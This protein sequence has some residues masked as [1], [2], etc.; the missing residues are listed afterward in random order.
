MRNFR[1]RT[2][3]PD[4]RL[5]EETIR[6]VGDLN[7]VIDIGLQIVDETKGRAPADADCEQW[8]V[9]IFDAREHWIMSLPFAMVRRLSKPA[10]PPPVERLR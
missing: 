6:P 10:D 3:T 9:D 8:L 7:E 4:G 2:V 1:F 5:I